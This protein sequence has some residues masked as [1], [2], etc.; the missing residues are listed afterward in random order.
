VDDP[1]GFDQDAL[2]RAILNDT[3][4]TEPLGPEDVEFREYAQQIK[5]YH[6]SVLRQDYFR[7]I[8]ANPDIGFRDATTNVSPNETRFSPNWEEIFNEARQAYT[9]EDDLLLLNLTHPEPPAELAD[10]LE[11]ITGEVDFTRWDAPGD[12]TLNPDRPPISQPIDTDIDVAWPDDDFP[13]FTNTWTENNQFRVV[14]ST[15]LRDAVLRAG[16]ENG[17]FTVLE[18]ANL[19]TEN[20][21]DAIS[22]IALDTIFWSIAFAPFGGVQDTGFED[23]SERAIRE[24]A[25]NRRVQDDA[26][27][28]RYLNTLPGQEAYVSIGGQWYLAEVQNAVNLH[29]MGYNNVNAATVTVDFSRGGGLTGSETFSVPIE[30]NT[31]RVADGTW[32]PDVTAFWRPYTDPAEERQVDLNNIGQHQGEQIYYEDQWRTLRAVRDNN[33]YG[34]NVAKILVWDDGSTSE[35]SGFMGRVPGLST[36]FYGEDAD[37]PPPPV[38]PERP[39][40]QMPLALNTGDTVRTDLGVGILDYQDPTN[41]V[42]MVQYVDRD[43]NVLQTVPYNRANLTKT[44]DPPTY[45]PAVTGEGTQQPVTAGEEQP[46]TARPGTQQDPNVP[47]FEEM[48][49]GIDLAR[50]MQQ[51]GEQTDDDDDTQVQ[52]TQQ[53]QQQQSAPGEVMSYL[54]REHNEVYTIWRNPAYTGTDE[55]RVERIFGGVVP[56]LSYNSEGHPILSNDTEIDH[57]GHTE[58]NMVH[59]APIELQEQSLGNVSPENVANISQTNPDE[60]PQAPAP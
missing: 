18:A 19:A 32:E 50:T 7:E 29:S 16:V 51:T 39:K 31:F 28:Q 15:E 47:T 42:F 53:Q 40:P 22:L 24:E 34:D 3:R 8:Q 44:T 1:P 9:N 20:M 23:T 57:H 2:D 13:R 21:L 33:T 45:Q 49:Q 58:F 27:N 54:L 26:T 14:D 38:Q 56:F 12:I 35:V 43:G 59:R 60:T 25:A 5:D 6:N 48:F 52:Q 55:N 46:V 11:E 17:D 30:F 4:V 37:L 41:D 36:R 10:D